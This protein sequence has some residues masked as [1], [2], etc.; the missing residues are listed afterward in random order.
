MSTQLRRISRFW[1]EGGY[2]S[3]PSPAPTFDRYWYGIGGDRVFR[4]RSPEDRRVWLMDAPEIRETIRSTHP[5]VKAAI[6][7][8]AWPDDEGEV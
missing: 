7:A 3:E 4:F 8:D 2:L 1:M 6:K 5:L